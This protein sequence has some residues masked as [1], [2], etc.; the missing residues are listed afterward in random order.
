MSFLFDRPLSRTRAW[1]CVLT[2]LAATPGLGSLMGRR[3]FAGIGQLI[4]ALVGFFLILGWMFKLFYRLFQEQLGGTVPQN[5]SGWMLKWGLIVFGMSWLW[6]LV[7]SVSLL[8]QA[9]MDERKNLENLPP[10]LADWPDAN[11]EK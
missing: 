6:S 10:K 3:I 4:L 11:S 7:T 2:N 9:K 8:W 5:S 1:T